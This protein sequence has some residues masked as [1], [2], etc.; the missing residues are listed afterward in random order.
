MKIKPLVSVVMPCYNAEKFVE[1]AVRS[2]MIQTYKSLEIITINDA[3]KDNTLSILTILAKADERIKIVNNEYNLQL[4]Q[5]LNLGLS[6]AKGKYIARM[7]ADDISMPDRIESQVAFL[8]KNPQT[9]LCGTNYIVIDDRNKPIKKVHFPT[10]NEE[11]KIQLLFSNPFAHPAVMIRKSVL[12]QYKEGLVPAEDY[13]LWLAIAQK[14]AVAN[15]PTV[16][17]KYRWHGDNI[18]IKQKDKK[19]DAFKKIID[20]YAKPYLFAESFLGWHLRFL[21]GKWDRQSTIR[22]I[23][24]FSLWKNEL[25]AKN[26]KLQLFNAKILEKVFDKNMALALFSII[27]SRENSFKVKLQSFRALLGI[28]WRLTLE[29]IKERI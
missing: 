3:S 11:L 10:G 28:D 8:E 23:S 21:E 4:V 22:E 6:I 19:A 14:Y 15:L 26:D 2:I 25:L 29:T 20:M 9:A 18:S 16:L 17:L 27:K 12:P 24:A 1:A 7:D 5:N 13:E